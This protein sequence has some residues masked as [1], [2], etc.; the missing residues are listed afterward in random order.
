MQMSDLLK[1]ANWMENDDIRPY[2]FVRPENQIAH[3]G[4]AHRLNWFNK[5]PVMKDPLDIPELAF[6]D[7]IYSLD[8]AIPF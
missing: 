8:R 4:S 5:K 1:K 2:V 7:R 3:P 6:A